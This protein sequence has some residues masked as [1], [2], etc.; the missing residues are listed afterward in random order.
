ML[1][2]FLGSLVCWAADHGVGLINMVTSDPLVLRMARRWFPVRTRLR[3]AFHS[4]DPEGRHMMRGTD[5]LWEFMDSDF[6]FLL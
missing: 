5:H 1:Y 4:N 2:R 3:F 6:D